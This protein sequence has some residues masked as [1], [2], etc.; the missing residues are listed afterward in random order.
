MSNFIKTLSAAVGAHQ[1]GNPLALAI[2]KL[3]QVRRDASMTASFESISSSDLLSGRDQLA[4][5]HVSQI[6]NTLEASLESLKS[7]GLIVDR[8]GMVAASIATAMAGALAKGRGAAYR[9]LTAPVAVSAESENFAVVNSAALASQAVERQSVSMEAYDESA[10][11]ITTIHSQQ[12]N[13]RHGNQDEFTE[14]FFPTVIVGPD[15]AGYAI[16]LNIVEVQN[17]IRREIT[18]K[19]D[20]FGRKNIIHALVDPSILTE[21]QTQLIP[22]VRDETE[23]LFVDP[24]IAP[25][26]THIQDGHPVETAPLKTRTKLPLLQI[27]QNDAVLQTGLMGVEESIAAG[28]LLDKIYIQIEGEVGGDTV[29]ELLEFTVRHM[30]TANFWAPPQGDYRLLRLAFNTKNLQLKGKPRLYGGGE[31]VLLAGLEGANLSVRLEVGATGS[32]NT[33]FGETIVS[34]EPI[35]IVSVRQGTNDLD[36]SDAVVAPIAAILATAKMVGYDLYAFRSNTTRRQRGQL[37]NNDYYTQMYPVVTRAPI[38]IPRSEIVD[39]GSESNDVAALLTA[40]GI[41]TTASGIETLFRADEIL[42]QHV[43]NDDHIT[44]APRVLGIARAAIKP[45]YKRM[46]IDVENELMTLN[47]TDLSRDVQ[48]V[49]VNPIRDAV[50][51]AYYK[52]AYKIVAAA[53][54]GGNARKPLVLIGTDPYT[55]NY[56]MLHGDLRTLGE[57]FDVKIV[58]SMHKDMEGKIFISFGSHEALGSNQPD[59]FHFGNMGWKT[60]LVYA[61]STH[62]QGANSKQ[63]TVQP[64]YAHWVNLPILIRVDVK[65]LASAIQ[66]RT[67]LHSHP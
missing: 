58:S 30:D 1:V 28:V 31:S 21:D 6:Y 20:D 14:T 9:E 56:L 23:H 54:H 26:R 25:V 7:E 39:S 63:I 35:S 22:V 64:T 66:K 8:P 52:S 57:H 10:L 62:Y 27:S 50:F 15:E 29:T 61:L 44:N 24:T 65:N 4:I 17:D 18:G 43:N 13:L 47:S 41:R 34:D 12:F 2:E 45:F 33:E 16:S 32:L 42:H 38:T 53:R 36:L 46:N 40:C 49:L 11:R 37:L 59:P 67:P 5:E 51:E 55:A 60:E 3:D 19:L 48:A